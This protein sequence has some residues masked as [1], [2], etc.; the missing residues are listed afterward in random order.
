M[1]ITAIT[2]DELR[3]KNNEEGLVLE[4][5]GGDLNDWVTG[6]N[7]MLTEEGILLDGSRMENCET[8]T[9]NGLMCLYF[10]FGDAKLDLGKFAI[11][12]LK[13]HGTFG[14]TWLSDY[15]PNRLGGFINENSAAAVSDAKLSVAQ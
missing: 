5:C 10:P 12:R 2:T 15:V 6:I 4:G 7:D 3:R 14:G 11:W 9:R 13:T 8:F 1:S